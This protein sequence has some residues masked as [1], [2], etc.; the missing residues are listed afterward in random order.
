[1]FGRGG[2]AESNNQYIVQELGKLSAA[3]N[4]REVR[5]GCQD[6]HALVGAHLP[7]LPLWQVGE[8]FAYRTEVVGLTKKPIGL[9]QDIQKW[10]YQAR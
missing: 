7:I 9:Y 5:Q 2:P 3:R 10:R 6:L 1:L 4:W 8:S